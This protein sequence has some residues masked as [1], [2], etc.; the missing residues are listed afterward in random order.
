MSQVVS[1]RS[2]IDRLKSRLRWEGLKVQRQAVRLATLVRLNAWLRGSAPI[3]GEAPAV[4]SLTSHSGRILHVQHTIFT[5]ATGIARPKRIIL[6]IGHGDAH[7]ITPELRSLE[8]RGLEIRLTEDC[9]P[10]TKYFPYCVAKSHV[11]EDRIPMVVADDDI[12]YPPNW[13]ADMI[14]AAADAPSPVIVAHRAHKI[15]LKDSTIAPYSTWD[16]EGGTVE[17]SFSNVAT[18]VC[19]VLYPIEFITKVRDDW[20]REFM[21]AARSADD[22]WLHTRS[23]LLGIPTKQVAQNPPLIVAHHPD[24]NSS[25][26]FVNVIGGKNDTVIKRIYTPEL[27]RVISDEFRENNVR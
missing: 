4:V 1:D 11:R 6:W 27:V 19:G 24:L 2:M 10:H 8:R 14:A 21:E 26:S 23:V 16:F 7:R 3:T 13:L 9:G 22:L 17:P 15:R 25:L 12:L 20:Q 5:I 18:G